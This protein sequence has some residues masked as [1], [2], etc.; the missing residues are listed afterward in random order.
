MSVSIAGRR[1]LM[2]VVL[3]IACSAALV[4]SQEPSA[5]TRGAIERG[6]ALFDQN[7]AT[8]HGKRGKGDAPA[9]SRMNPRPTDLTMLR[10]RYGT[11]PAERVEAILKGTDQPQAHTPTMTAWKALFLADANGNEA[12]ADA[13]VK[14][15]VAFI[16]SLQAK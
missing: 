7:C 12:T 1:V 5:P 2:M 3:T 8:C 16:A 14:D 6:H 10:R 9:A 13:H 4:A 15:V 11:F